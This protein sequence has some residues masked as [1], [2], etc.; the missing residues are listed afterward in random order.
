MDWSAAR[1]K[2][3]GQF[4]EE[5]RTVIFY[6]SPHRIVKVLQDIKDVLNNSYVVCARELTKKFEEVKGGTASELLDHFSTKKPRGEFVLIVHPAI[7]DPR[8]G[9]H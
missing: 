2:K 1:R 6:E 3:L 7:L 5:K 8:A 4:K 9:K